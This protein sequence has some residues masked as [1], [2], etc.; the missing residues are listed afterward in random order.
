[1]RRFMFVLVL[2]STLVVAGLAQAAPVVPFKPGTTWIYRSTKTPA[3]GRATAETLTV[4]YKGQTTYRGKTYHEFESRSSTSRVV[5]RSIQVWAGGHFRQAAMVRVDGRKTTETVFDKPYPISGATQTAAGSSQIYENGAPLSR[6]AWSIAV[7]RD[8]SGKV[9][10]PA[11]TFTADKWN[12]TL[13][14]GDVKHVYVVYGVG[15][16]EVRSDF[17]IF[18]K[19]QFNSR[20]VRE[21]QQ[22]SVPK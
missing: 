17:D 22:G 4:A 2:M 15:P 18:M 10:V 13:V 20:L 8:G 9:T 19:G 6:G 7:S 21:L 3:Q 1:M 5:E 11:G 12:G 14:L 16:L